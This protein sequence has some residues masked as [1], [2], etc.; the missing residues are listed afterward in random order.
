[1]VR[2]DVRNS[3]GVDNLWVV[4]GEPGPCSADTRDAP[5]ASAA[6]AAAASRAD[7]GAVVSSAHTWGWARSRAGGV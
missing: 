7:G 1:M 3:D 4:W 2:V 6:P 5:R